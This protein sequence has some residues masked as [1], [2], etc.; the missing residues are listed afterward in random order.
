MLQALSRE[1]SAGL[2]L[3]GLL[4][5]RPTGPAG[6]GLGPGYAIGH[7]EIVALAGRDDDVEAAFG[8]APRE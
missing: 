8:E 2:E 5:A 1:A 4:R 7:V 3:I 6:A